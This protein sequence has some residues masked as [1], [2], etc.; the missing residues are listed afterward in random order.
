MNKRKILIAALSLCIVAILAVGTSLAYLV[1]NDQATN[2]F[3]VG[4]ISI[5]LIESQ[6]HRVNGGKGYTTEEEPI[7]GG[8]VWASNVEPMGNGSDEESDHY[9]PSVLY[10]NTNWDSSYFSDKQILDD[11]KNTF[12]AYFAKEAAYMVPGDNVRKNPYVR[13]TSLYN[14]A[15]VRVHVLIPADLF[16][17]L[18]NGFSYWTSTAI[19]VGAIY[20]NAVDSYVANGNDAQKWID[21]GKAAEFKVTDANGKDYYKFDFTYTDALEPG[22]MTFWNCWGNIAIDKN[23]TNKQ[24]EEVDTFDVLIYADGIQ[25][26]GFAS[27]KDAFAAFD[28]VE[29]HEKVFEDGFQVNS[30]DA[31]KATYDVE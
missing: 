1:D 29:D 16:V 22:A 8:Y 11:A 2:V 13:N 27:A 5:D 7:I 12:Q 18:D 6:Y 19:K 3:T 25:A 21:S 14:E 24:L 20:S 28:S 26:E 30:S 9:T 17:I 10:E 31:A 23:T 4:N 15:Y